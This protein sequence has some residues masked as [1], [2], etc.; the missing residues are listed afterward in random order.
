MASYKK[1]TR[2]CCVCHEHALKS[3]ML[4]FVRSKDGGV[5][6][7]PSQSKEGRGAYVHEGECFDKLK[8]KNLLSA[9]FK[10]AVPKDVYDI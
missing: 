1:N 5:T 2:K 9:A 8:R 3:E 6:F 10:T 7:D 4:R